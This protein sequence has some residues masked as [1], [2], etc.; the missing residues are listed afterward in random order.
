MVN[1]HG[2]IVVQANLDIITA[3]EE[4]AGNAAN[5]AVKIFELRSGELSMMM[6]TNAEIFAHF[7]ATHSVLNE[8]DVVLIFLRLSALKQ[9]YIV[10]CMYFWSQLDNP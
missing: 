2:N 10:T 7:E 1:A 6:V 3:I 8:D 5:A 9:P 4:P